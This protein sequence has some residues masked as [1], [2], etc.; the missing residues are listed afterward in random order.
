[1]VDSVHASDIV[2][3]VLPPVR[4]KRFLRISTRNIEHRSA[5]Q[6]NLHRK[7]TVLWRCT[8]ARRAKSFLQF[9]GWNVEMWNRNDDL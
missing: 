2:T 7:E 4:E 6:R 1:M 3:N 9:A 8:S 5:S